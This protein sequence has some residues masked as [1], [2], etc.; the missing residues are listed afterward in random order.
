M[1]TSRNGA[2]DEARAA[3]FIW[4]RAAG[5]GPTL[6]LFRAASARMSVDGKA[7]CGA[8]EGEPIQVGR[9][10]CEACLHELQKMGGEE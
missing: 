9:H 6:H 4:G 3:G 1:T 7:V 10:Y 8:G 5:G 2:I